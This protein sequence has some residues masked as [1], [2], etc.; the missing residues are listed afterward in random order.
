MTLLH[1]LHQPDSFRSCTWN[2][3]SNPDLAFA[4]VTSTLP[5]RLV[6]D[7]FPRSQ[8]RPTLLSHFT[9]LNL[10][11]QR[12]LGDE[13]SARPNGNSLQTWW[14]LGLIRCLL[15]VPQAQT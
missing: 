1:D 3:T 5:Q 2:T 10:F 13:T 12:M 7:P 9:Q 8:H 15:P 4:N 14:N 11:Q 6:L